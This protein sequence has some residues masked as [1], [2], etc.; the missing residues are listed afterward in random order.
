MSAGAPR[1][2]SSRRMAE[3][4][5]RQAGLSLNDWL[6]RVI[7]EGAQGP[8]PNEYGGRSTGGYL[9]PSRLTPDPYEARRPDDSGRVTQAIENLSERIESAETRQALAIANVASSSAL[10]F[11]F[12]L[13]VTFHSLE[14][15]MAG[16]MLGEITGTTFTLVVTRDLFKPAILDFAKAVAVGLLVLVVAIALGFAGVGVALIPSVATVAAGLAV[17][18]VWALSFTP[19]LFEASFPAMRLRA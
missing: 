5:A 2:P 19:A 11:E 16:R 10:I 12:V 18:A 15:V 6:S 17:F 13:L 1:D 4:L 8:A 9:E 7:A 14:A 3:D